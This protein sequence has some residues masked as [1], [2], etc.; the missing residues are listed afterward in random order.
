MGKNR[1]DG[2]PASWVSGGGVG[3]PVNPSRHF[4][5]HGLL[6]LQVGLG[7]WSG[8]RPHGLGRCGLGGGARASRQGA[9]P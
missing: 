3:Y 8:A 5:L 4:P 1:L 9:R 7:A 2:S 6:G